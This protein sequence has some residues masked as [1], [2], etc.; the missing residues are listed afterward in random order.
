MKRLFFLLG[1]FIFLSGTSQ[2]IN[3]MVLFCNDGEPFTL[4]LNGER[5]NMEPQTRVRVEGLTLKKY[6]AKVIFKNKK[7]KEANTTITFFYTCFECEFG[8]NRKSK[9]KFKIEYFTDRKIEGC[10]GG[11]PEGNTNSNQTT[12][13]ITNTTTNTPIEEATPV[14]TI[15]P[16]NTLLTGPGTGITTTDNNTVNI[17]NGKC[18]TPMSDSQFLSFKNSVQNLP[19]DSEKQIKA[20]AM[21]QAACITVNQLRQLLNVFFA[22]NAKYEFAKKV[23][24]RTKDNADFIKLKEVFVDTMVKDKFEKFL[25]T[26]K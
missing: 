15:T 3:N 17:I 23:Y 26:K 18:D 8:V 1:C 24:E 9:K 25:Q 13:T 14:Q 6:Q 22:D 10:A 16:T 20:W 19:T 5:M 4:I 7:L 21:M 2:T 11:E 12:G